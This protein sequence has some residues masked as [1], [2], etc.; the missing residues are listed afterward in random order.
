[1]APEFCTGTQRPCQND[2]LENSSEQT[3]PGH[4]ARGCKLGCKVTLSLLSDVRIQSASGSVRAQQ[5]TPGEETVNEEGL[6]EEGHH[7]MLGIRT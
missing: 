6:E 3:R 4:Q 7:L 1:M 2:A 5:R